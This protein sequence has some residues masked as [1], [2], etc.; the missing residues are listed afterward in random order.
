[1]LVSLAT[2]R[3]ASWTVESTGHPF[4]RFQDAKANEGLTSSATLRTRNFTT[5]DVEPLCFFLMRS[6]STRIQPECWL[7]FRTTRVH[8]L[9]L[10]L[11]L[12]GRL[13]LMPP[14]NH[15][16]PTKRMFHVLRE[17]SQLISLWLLQLKLTSFKLQDL[18]TRYSKEVAPTSLY[19]GIRAT[20]VFSLPS[21][22]TI[23]DIPHIFRSDGSPTALIHGLDLSLH[24]SQARNSRSQTLPPLLSDKWNAE[25]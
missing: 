21:L 9:S 20:K 22:F 16:G 12:S 10:L 3:F 23:Y 15:V 4:T 8:H 14:I 6:R 11:P 19:S 25:I 1:M 18:N 7:P 5:F 2:R 24:F 13:I 17:P